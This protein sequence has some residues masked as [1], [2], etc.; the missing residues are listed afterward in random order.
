MTAKPFLA[1]LW[2][3]TRLRLTRRLLALRVQARHPGLMT[4]P[5]AIWDYAWRDVGDIGIGRRVWVGPRCEILV[6]RRAAHSSVPGKLVLHDGAVVSTGCNLRAAGG[7]IELGR[8]TAVG[9]NCVLV[10]ANHATGTGRPHLMSPWNEERTGVI[11]G[12]NVWVGANC[13]LLPG[14]RIGDSAVIAAGSV[15]RGAVPAGEIWG[16]VPARRL[17]A[18][19]AGLAAAAAAAAR[20]MAAT[21][22][23]QG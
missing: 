23:P 10:A 4:D 2:R 8:A 5:T 12:D 9:Q 22:K 6:Y 3:G 20:A 14:T 7:R 11:L 13:T 17:R 1:A 18:A 21:G 15:V 19:D 16:G